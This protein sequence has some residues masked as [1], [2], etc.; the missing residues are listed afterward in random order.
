MATKRRKTNDLIK[1]N[2][3]LRRAYFYMMTME[4]INLAP[5]TPWV[6]SDPFLYHWFKLN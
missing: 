4:I 2:R 1:L 3:A 5:K 6:V